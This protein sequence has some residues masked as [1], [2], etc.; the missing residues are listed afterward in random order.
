MNITFEKTGSGIDKIVFEGDLDY[1]ASSEI[2]EKVG[3]FLA[4]KPQKIIFDLGKV[5]YMDSSGI[6]A[7]VEVSRKSKDF[8]GRIVFCNITDSVRSIFELAK[9]NL[10]FTL[11]GSEDEAVQALNS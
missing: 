10:F 11:A 9:L 4:G 5:P 8:G 2:R 3:T 6:A 7:F 1:H